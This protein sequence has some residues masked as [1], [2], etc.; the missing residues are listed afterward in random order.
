[1]L[2]KIKLCLAMATLTMITMAHPEINGPSIDPDKETEVV[3]RV[4]ISKEPLSLELQVEL[5]LVGEFAAQCF[6][7]ALYEKKTTNTFSWQ[8]RPSMQEALTWGK[9]ELKRIWE[10]RYKEMLTGVA[11]GIGSSLIA[12]GIKLSQTASNGEPQ[13]FFE[14]AQLLPQSLLHMIPKQMAI[15]TIVTFFHELGHAAGHY[16]INGHFADIYLGSGQAV[17]PHTT[18]EVLPHLKLCSLDPRESGHIINK[19]PDVQ[20]IHP[21]ELFTLKKMILIELAQNNPDAKLIDLKNSP[22]YAEKI[23]TH[24]ALI[25]NA[26]R[27]LHFVFHAAGPIAGL[28]SNAVLKYLQGKSLLIPTAQDYPQ[29]FS[30][31]PTKGSDGGNILSEVFN[32]PNLIK[33]F[34]EYMPHFLAFI[35][36]SM[37]S[38]SLHD[39]GFFEHLSATNNTN[40]A[41]A[42]GDLLRTLGITII[43]ICGEGFIA[44]SK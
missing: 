39:T 22:L 12:L 9:N 37:I 20:R 27:Q 21:Q 28:C 32:R 4:P 33:K 16:R 6:T 13:M 8:N 43:N 40:L 38:K 34:G 10:N 17:L 29:F 25:I 36:L 18:L 42:A 15:Q 2:H 3:S 30:L 7:Q 44:I 1:M 41:I 26:N 35:L 19:L 11:L 24:V 14:L 23:A 31:F 5:L